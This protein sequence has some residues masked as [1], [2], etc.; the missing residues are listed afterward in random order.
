MNRILRIIK[1][2]E[3][4]DGGMKALI[5]LMKASLRKEYQEN[6]LN[7]VKE[8]KIKSTTEFLDN[9]NSISL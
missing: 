9:C 5:S 8:G 7:A 3:L 6:F 2:N 4:D 1:N